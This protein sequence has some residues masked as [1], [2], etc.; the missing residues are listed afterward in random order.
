MIARIAAADLRHTVA[1]RQVLPLVGVAVLLLWLAIVAGRGAVLALQSAGVPITGE[2]QPTQATPQM[3]WAAFL[4]GIT[5]VGAAL[6]TRRLQP[7]S[8][9]PVTCATGGIV[10]LAGAVGSTSVPSLLLVT[11]MFVLS[12]LL[13]AALLAR[14]PETPA[15]AVVR[16]PIAIALGT[17]LL[18]LLLLAL[19]TPGWLNAATVSASAGIIVLGVLLLQRRQLGHELVRLRDWRPVP[20][21][22][23]ET[24]VLGLTVGLLAYAALGAFVPETLTDSVR[25]H[26]PIARE[27]WQSGTAADFAFLGVSSNPIQ[28]H[29]LYAVA[30]GFGDMTAAKLVH[31]FTGLVAILGLAGVAWLGARPVEARAAPATAWGVTNRLAAIVGAA[32]FATMPL[33]LWELGTALIDLFPVFFTVAVVLCVLLWQRDGSL[34]WLISAGALASFGFAAKMTIGLLMGVAL[35]AAILLVG[36]GAW[37][38]RERLLAVVAFGLGS[39]V[40]LPWLLRSYSLTGAIPGVGILTDNATGTATPATSDLA[41]YGLGRSLLDLVGIPWHLTFQGELFFLS[42]DVGILLLMLLPL[43]L[44]VPRTRATAFLAVTV[45]VSFLGWAYTAQHTR[46]LLPTLAL[47]AALAGI[48]VASL[49]TSGIVNAPVAHARR[50]LALAVPAGLVVGLL[51]AP[52]LLIFSVRSGLA[53]DVVTGNVSTKEFIAKNVPAAAA[54]EAASTLPPDTPVE[55]YGSWYGMQLYTEAR[56]TYSWIDTYERTELGLMLPVIDQEIAEPGRKPGEVLDSLNRSGI[57]YFLWDRNGP[58]VQ[59]FRTTLLSTDF[60]RAHTRILAGDQGGYLFEVLPHGGTGWGE[61]NQNLLQDPGLDTVGDDAPWATK[62]QVKLHRGF[63]RLIED[64]SS[65][66]QRVTVSAGRP[67]LLLADGRCPDPEQSATLSL[68][69]FD[70]DNVELGN[71][72]EQVIPGTALSEQF[73]WHRAPDRTTAASV[74]LRRAPGCEFD[75]IALYDAS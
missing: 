3:V 29:L 24:V 25:Q 2:P 36:R 8:T 19:A 72:A 42:G 47:S 48:G 27:I 17:G 38:W 57:R 59:F 46:Y 67:Y 20:P 23:L 10:I 33:V 65:L 66:T 40:V 41:S 1:A 56:L 37:H 5:C 58:V 31:T 15:V 63:V 50:L 28:A 45:G 68:R 12:G 64:K 75:R 39:L 70:A 54:L 53:V 26:L 74:E 7:A 18:G 55:Y 34:A 30:Y 52:V 60:L 51:A 69:W 6:I 4:V 9:I 22:W 32:I 16:I 35:V 14:L 49:I 13:G 62:K 43:G 61:S 21:T 73:L 71:D 11:A 44:F